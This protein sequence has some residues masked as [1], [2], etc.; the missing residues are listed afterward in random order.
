M[1]ATLDRAT[2]SRPA[3]R[4]KFA[5]ILRGQLRGEPQ[6]PRVSLLDD[7]LLIEWGR[8]DVAIS[9]DDDGFGYAVRRGDQFEPGVSDKWSGAVSEIR[10]ALALSRPNG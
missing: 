10:A 6:S 7:E 1:L 5:E 9:I 8:P 4:A 3:L 2:T